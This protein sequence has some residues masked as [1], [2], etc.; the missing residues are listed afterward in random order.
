MGL[1][2]K[3]IFSYVFKS[4]DPVSSLKTRAEQARIEAAEVL[5]LLDEVSLKFGA[6]TD[7][8]P[9][10]RVIDVSV[11]SPAS[12]LGVQ[13]GDFFFSYDGTKLFD[14]LHEDLD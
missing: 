4:D 8:R 14:R 7:W 9:M 11:G 3:L 2:V 10:P 12:K 1:G 6:R 5:R 13:P